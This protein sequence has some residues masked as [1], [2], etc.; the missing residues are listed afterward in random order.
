MPDEP[1]PL[2]RYRTY[3][4]LLARAHLRSQLRGRL[5]DSDVVQQTLLEAHRHAGQY[6]GTTS[7][8]LA[9]WLRQIL[10]RQLANALRDETRQRRDVRRQRSLE[11]AVEQSSARLEQW[12]AAEQSSPSQHVERDEQLLRLAGALPE[13]PEGQREAVEMRYLHGLSLQEIAEQLGRT[14]EA[15]AGLLHRGLEAL[16]RRLEGP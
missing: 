11:E 6:R 7:G 2:E 14:P 8:E 12:L 10:A 3:L 16:R 15:V 13:L 9:A 4:R 1:L 5:D